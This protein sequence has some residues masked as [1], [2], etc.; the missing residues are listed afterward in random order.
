MAKNCLN[1]LGRGITTT[2]N[3]PIVGIKE[4]YLMHVEDVNPTLDTTSGYWD[5]ISFSPGTNSYKVEGY[6]QNIQVTSAVRSLDASNKLDISVVFKLPHSVGGSDLRLAFMR[7]IL[8]G[9][10]YVLVI[11]NDTSKFIV[12]AQS[13]LECSGLDWDSNA[14]GQMKTITLT[15]P[16]G[17]AGNYFTDLTVAVLNEIISK[18]L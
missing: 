9:K 8:T 18:A 12:G 16:D 11:C 10:F 13:P 7:A 14:N 6:K 2:C 5:A 3:M 15:T 1:R 4:L 17:S